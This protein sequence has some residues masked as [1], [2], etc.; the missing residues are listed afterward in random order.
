MAKLYFKYGAMASGKS[1]DLL[2]VSFNY[3]E[4]GEKVICLTS[5]KDNRY[6][7]GKIVSRIG[8]QAQAM[9]VYEDMNVYDLIYTLWKAAMDEGTKISCVLVDEA[10][11]FT[12]DQVYQLSNIVDNLNIPV[13]CYGIRSDSNLELFEG[14][15]H[16]LILADSIE[17]IK[18]ICCNC[19]SH[20]AIINARFSNNKIVASGP[21][22]QIGGNETYRSLC[23]KCYKKEIEK[24]AKL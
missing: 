19:R 5:A 2:K 11:F 13:M 21:Q 4:Y 8:I 10:Q 12:K 3:T 17:E 18:T 24:N 15:K 7:Q 9:S 20:K 23:R 6:G 14:S 22:I 16:L 1:I